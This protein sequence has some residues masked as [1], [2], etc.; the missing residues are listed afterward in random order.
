MGAIHVL[1][2]VVKANTLVGA[3]LPPSIF[4]GA[5]MIC[6][7]TGGTESKFATF[8]MPNKLAPKITQFKSCQ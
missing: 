3:P 2:H 5:T 8:S 7:P 6:E 4:M 1:G